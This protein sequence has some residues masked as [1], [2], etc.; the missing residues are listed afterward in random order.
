M[1]ITLHQL[2]ILAGNCVIRLTR[3]FAIRGLFSVVNNSV[4]WGQHVL[5]KFIKIFFSFLFFCLKLAAMVLLFNLGK[6][7]ETI[8]Y[9]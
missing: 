2:D 3:N 4:S 7:D 8:F 5:I 9:L 1:E 6:V